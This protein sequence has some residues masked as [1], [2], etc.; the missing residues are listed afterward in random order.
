MALIRRAAAPY[1]APRGRLPAAWADPVG[2]L[3]LLAVAFLLWARGL[4][5]DAAPAPLLAEP[6]RRAAVLAWPPGGPPPDAPMQVRSSGDG[7]VWARS[8]RTAELAW[9]DA[10]GRLRA[11]PLRVPG[12]PPPALGDGWAT[13][14][15]PDAGSWRWQASDGVRTRPL[16]RLPAGAV[17]DA[18]AVTEG[19]AAL[20]W[21]DPDLRPRVDFQPLVGGTPWRLDLPRG[22]VLQLV[23]AGPYLAALVVEL[24]PEPRALVR[25]WTEAGREAGAWSAGEPP[26]RIVYA[27]RPPRVVWSVPDDGGS[28]LLTLD[29][30]E[31]VTA[32]PRGLGRLPG[33][34][35]AAWPLNPGRAWAALVEPGGEG[36]PAVAV[37][38]GDVWSGAREP[39]L[40]VVPAG[41]RV[42][43]LD[44]GWLVQSGMRLIAHRADGRVSWS[45]SL[46][47]GGVVAAA[48]ARGLLVAADDRIE[49]WL[50]R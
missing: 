50:P 8:G 10:A 38:R 43:G 11:G 48:W 12:M 25:A 27:G 35:R 33:T 5:T 21:H 47:P 32:V 42:L 26:G 18:L 30:D 29:L 31:R 7:L 4:G 1:P 34:V 17:P 14:V 36:A 49:I 6:P 41:A 44:G 3:A 19:G 24:E 40:H 13:W 20:A 15:E 16:G 23:G 28:R 45:Q 46:A 2:V 22:A 39:A 9:L 37:L